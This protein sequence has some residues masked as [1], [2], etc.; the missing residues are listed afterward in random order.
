MHP[1]WTAL[2]VVEVAVGGI[3]LY[4]GFVGTSTRRFEQQLRRAGADPRAAGP[5]LWIQRAMG[6]ALL[7]LGVCGLTGRL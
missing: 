4:T 7:V 2:H 6:A 1:W 5:S 3:W